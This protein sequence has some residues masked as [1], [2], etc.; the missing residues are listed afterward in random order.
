M[1]GSETVYGPTV[2]NRPANLPDFERPPLVEVN[3]GIEFGAL[4][5][6]RAA[7]VGLFW[8]GLRADYPALQEQPP[9]NS[10]IERFDEPDPPFSISFEFAESPPPLRAWLLS[11]DSS[12]LLQIQ[13]DRFIHNWRRMT[14]EAPY[15][16]YE[17]VRDEF[18]TRLQQF[19]SFVKAEELGTVDVVQA[20]VNYVNEL[21]AGD[22]WQGP[23]DLGEVVTMWK[24][25]EVAGLRTPE[26]VRVVERH[27][28]ETDDGAPARLYISLTPRP[29]VGGKAAALL[30]LTVRGRPTD[31][32][33][34]ISGFFD[35]G[36]Q[37]IVRT[38]AGV[39]TSAMHTLWRRTN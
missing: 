15:P 25:S 28:V 16:R 26:E 6:M 13:N 38:F 20:E 22:V 7:H 9:L 10:A 14:P 11:P 19:T 39:T 34:G 12:R 3:L 21:V 29:N 36:R 23:S 31:G 4:R 32:P 2:S 27:R 33:E 37:L 5:P 35:F 18:S 30:T 1:S 8:S 24:A 17:T